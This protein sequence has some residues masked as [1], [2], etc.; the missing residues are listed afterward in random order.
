MYARK[1]ISKSATPKEIQDIQ[2][3][4]IRLLDS[5]GVVQHHDAV[6]GT[7]KQYVS[8]DY[9]YRLQES[10]DKSLPVYKHE[11]NQVLKQKYGIEVEEKD[12]F[13]CVGQQND[14]VNDCPISKK[15]FQNKNEILVAVHNPQ[16]KG[17]RQMLKILLP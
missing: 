10:I 14:T 15:D 1:V 17:S 5:L 8:D 4:H 16:Q 2:K 7:S 3:A 11:I 6:S 13:T 12:M 9:S